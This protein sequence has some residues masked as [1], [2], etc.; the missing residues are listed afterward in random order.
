MR[1]YMVSGYGC[2][3]SCWPFWWLKA[4]K[5]MMEQKFGTKI[6]S[7]WWL[8]AICCAEKS[9]LRTPKKAA[10]LRLFKG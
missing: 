1:K 4:G 3:D 10:A 9:A 6:L 2:P 8:T 5:I 7:L